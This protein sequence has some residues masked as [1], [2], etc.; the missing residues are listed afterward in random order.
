MDAP[1]SWATQKKQQQQQK[2]ILCVIE[3]QSRERNNNAVEVIEFALNQIYASWLEAR[4]QQNT[5]QKKKYI[6]NV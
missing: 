6:Y 1:T 3:Y 4:Q 5:T 2:Y